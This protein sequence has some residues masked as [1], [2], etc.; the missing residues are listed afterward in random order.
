[1][2]K[3]PTWLD[4][5]GMVW[6][7]ALL[8]FL[9]YSACQKDQQV[10]VVKLQDGKSVL[11]LPVRMKEFIEGYFENYRLPGPQDMI[12]DWAQFKKTVP[13]AAWGDFNGDRLL[14]LALVLLGKD[15]W[16]LAELH[17]T[18]D[19]FFK[20]VDIEGSLPGKEL[21]TRNNNP[22]D[23]Y[24]FVVPAGQKLF[25]EEKPVEASEHA[26]DSVAFFCIR[27]PESGMLCSWNPDTGFHSTMRFN[28]FTD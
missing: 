5:G 9:L 10:P 17:Q 16:R 7:G 20:E 6:T 28:N 15:R 24:V 18:A 27:S 23:Y 8:L 12:G 13:Y 1:V 3:R 11:V 25:V 21:F 2:R 14:D 19:G 22:Q 26:H 4:Q